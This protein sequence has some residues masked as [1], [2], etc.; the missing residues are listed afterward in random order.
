M[1]EKIIRT[2]A[3]FFLLFFRLD[4]LAE[5]AVQDAFESEVRDNSQFASVYGATGLPP[6][7]ELRWLGL[8]RRRTDLLRRSI[9]GSA[10]LVVMAVATSFLVAVAMKSL[11]YRFTIQTARVMQA[12]SLGIFV[13]ATLAQ[14]GWEI[15]SYSGK[16]LPERLNRLWFRVLYT[17]GAFVGGLTVWQ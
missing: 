9:A 3:G 7:E 14:L 17:I 6:E 12:V 10:L 15:Q 11:G 4:R 16:S 5:R 1:F 2:T 8:Q 13:W